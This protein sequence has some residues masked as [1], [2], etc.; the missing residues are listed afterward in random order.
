MAAMAAMLRD[1]VV[2]L[3]RPRA[4]PLAKKTIRKSIHGFPLLS[5]IAM[6]LHGV[7]LINEKYNTNSGDKHF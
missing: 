2:V 6:D 3:T 4:I 5:Y 7:P 1:S